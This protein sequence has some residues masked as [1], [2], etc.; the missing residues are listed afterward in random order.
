MGGRTGTHTPA[1]LLFPLE[2]PAPKQGCVQ[3]QLV[4]GLGLPKLMPG[5]VRSY[6]AFKLSVFSGSRGLAVGAEMAGEAS[7]AQTQRPRKSPKK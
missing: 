3:G 7:W 6:E 2:L 5:T 4:S 1:A